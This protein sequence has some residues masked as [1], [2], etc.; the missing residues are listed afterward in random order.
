MPEF[1][2]ETGTLALR[3]VSLWRERDTEFP[4]LLIHAVA[5]QRNS[6]VGANVPLWE[7]EWRIIMTQKKRSPD[8]NAPDAENSEQADE[9]SQA[10]TVAEDAELAQT[11]LSEDSERGGHDDP[12][13]LIPNDVPDLVEH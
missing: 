10:Q 3:R 1:A 11:D 12:A 7:H 8:F 6:G 9:G 4:G 5:R 2:G 13:Q